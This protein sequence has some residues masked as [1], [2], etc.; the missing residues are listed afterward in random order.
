MRKLILL[1]VFT[2]A[3]A[4]INFAQSSQQNEQGTRCDPMLARFDSIIIAANSLPDKNKVIIVVVYLGRGEKTRTYNQRRLQAI[5][6]YFV[7][8]R[9]G[10]PEDKLVLTEGKNRNGLAM[11]EFYVNGELSDQFYL[12]KKIIPC[13]GF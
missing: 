6:K 11:I 10:I 5:K 7:N 8:G 4:N 2:C 3:F 13:T 12:S 9:S 1:F